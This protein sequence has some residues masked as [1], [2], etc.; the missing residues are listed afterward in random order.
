MLSYVYPM[1][2]SICF[3]S[4]NKCRCNSN[5]EVRHTESELLGSL[6]CDGV[7]EEVEKVRVST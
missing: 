5:L 2:W 7:L 3:S 4:M 6:Y 1:G